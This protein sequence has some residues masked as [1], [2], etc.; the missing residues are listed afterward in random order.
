MVRLLDPVMP[1]LRTVNLL[2]RRLFWQRF[3]PEPYLH[4]R[5]LERAVEL[6]TADAA[7]VEQEQNV[8]QRIVQLSEIRV[9]ELMRPRPQFRSFRP[10]V[11]LADLGGR[12]PPSGYL[13]VAEP[14]SDEIRAAIPLRS[15]SEVPEE[16]LDRLAGPVVYVP[17]CTT[18]AH[19]LEAMQRHQ[20]P[21]AAVINE[22]GETIGILTFDDV[23]ETIFG[24]APSRSLRLL[25]RAPIRQVAPETWQVTGMTSLWRLS[26][27]FRV[28]R[29]P[30]KSVTVAGVIQETLERFPDE[31]DE[32][33]WG[34]FQFKVVETPERGQLL[35]EL[36]VVRE[37]EEEK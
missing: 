24:R 9:D 25:R 35:V 28:Q 32:C 7:L 6:S 18:V 2:S 12:M 31:G 20:H 21:V 16:Q 26:R 4:V 27:Y 3:K 13:L 17:W 36:R 34:P 23:L 1:A 33:R 30:S 29:P 37:P 22:Y 8:L 11:R 5:D 10:P 19:A 15:L 14:Q